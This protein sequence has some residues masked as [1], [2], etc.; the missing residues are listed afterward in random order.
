MNRRPPGSTRTDP[1]FPYTTLFR[2]PGVGADQRAVLRLLAAAAAVVVR[3][4]RRARGVLQ[5]GHGAALPAVPVAG[6]LG[7][8]R[9]PRAPH[10]LRR[11]GDHRSGT[12]PGCAV[13]GAVGQEPAVMGPG[14]VAEAE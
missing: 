4:D 9:P 13:A 14:L 11:A 12:G 8:R 2:A 6:R 1:L 7:R 5:V 10:H 3:R